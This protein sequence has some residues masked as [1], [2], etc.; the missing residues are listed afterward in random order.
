M[1]SQ[2]LTVFALLALTLAWAFAPA[3]YAQSDRGSVTGT[4][5]DPGG[6]VIANAKVTATS[7]DTGEVREV[8]SSDEGNYTLPELKAGLYK[9]TVEAPGFKTA[10][11]EGVKVAVQVTHSLDFRLE[12]GAVTDVVTVT[13]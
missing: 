5:T 11:N 2:R 10:S 6:A 3:A 1:K 4:V 9:I 13:A 8:V 12:V 7:Q